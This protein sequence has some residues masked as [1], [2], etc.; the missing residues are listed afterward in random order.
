MNYTARGKE[1]R[2]TM[3]TRVVVHWSFGK[4]SAVLVELVDQLNTDGPA[5]DGELQ[6]RDCAAF[7]QAEVTINVA[8][9]KKE[10]QTS[11]TIVQR[12]ENFS[13]A[14]VCA[15]Y[16][17]TIDYV[18]LRREQPVEHGQFA[19]VILAVAIGVEDEFLPGGGKAATQGGAISL[20]SRVSDNA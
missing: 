9:R 2:S 3:R 20:V 7:K 17:K 16:L 19:H 12:P 10:K 4:A 6:G 8:D 11:Q 15:F 14:T 13:L 18:N 5:I 1:F